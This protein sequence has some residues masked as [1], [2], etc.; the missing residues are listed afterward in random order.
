MNLTN[1]T[2]ADMLAAVERLMAGLKLPVNERKTRCLRCPEEAF[3][4]LGYRIG[5]VYR[6]SGR[7]SYIG[8]RPSK[9]SVQRIS[10]RISD[11]TAPKHG[12]QS[13]EAMVKR[14]NR[15]MVGWAHYF[16]LGNVSPAYAAVNQHA[17]RRLRQWLGRKYR[18][19]SG[20]YVRIPV[21]RLGPDYG[22]FR[23]T[24]QTL[25]LPSAKA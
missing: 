25:G 7:G 18:T 15:T 11:M 24:R 3:E 12:W 6:P 21:Q 13:P 9:A 17:V 14:L 19:N 16:S 20:N 4:F 10:R 1:V 23:L 2:S 8:T 22:L 5:R